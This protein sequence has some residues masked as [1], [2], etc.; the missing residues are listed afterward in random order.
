MESQYGYRKG[1]NTV[2]C[3]VKHAD[4]VQ[5]FVHLVSAYIAVPRQ[6]CEFKTKIRQNIA[7]IV[8]NPSF[9][10]AM[11]ALSKFGSPYW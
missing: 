7:S 5:F 9:Y 11:F 6:P 2:H 1:P 10:Y 3:F 4:A 8:N